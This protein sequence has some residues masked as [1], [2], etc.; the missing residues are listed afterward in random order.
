MKIKNIVLA[1]V[2]LIVLTLLGTAVMKILDLLFD[3]EYESISRAGFKVG[4]AAWLLLI[5]GNVIYKLRK[6]SKTRKEMFE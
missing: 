6:E 2:L 3:L 5:V 1:I 4:F